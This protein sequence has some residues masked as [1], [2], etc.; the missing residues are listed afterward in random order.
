MII[1]GHP[2]EWEWQ[3][4]VLDKSGFTPEIA[5]HIECC[6][7]CQAQLAA[8]RLLFAEIKQQPRPAFTFSVPSLILPQLQGQLPLQD[9]PGLTGS[10]RVMQSRLSGWLLTLLIVCPPGFAVYLFRKNIRNMFSE[11]SGL[12]VWIILGAALLIVLSGIRV[13][14]RKYQRQ[15]EALHFY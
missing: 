4:Y 1:D 12:F 2:S 13:M 10:R 8:Y 7:D 3:Q 5:E 14:Y 9:Q 11:I 6:D 15:L